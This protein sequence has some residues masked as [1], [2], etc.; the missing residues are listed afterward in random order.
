MANAAREPAASHGGGPGRV[1]RADDCSRKRC[2]GGKPRHCGRYGRVQSRGDGSGPNGGTSGASE[3]EPV[4]PVRPF[5]GWVALAGHCKRSTPC[6]SFVRTR[7]VRFSADPG[8]SYR[9]RDGAVERCCG[10]WD[11]KGRGLRWCNDRSAL[12]ALAG[13]S[14]DVDARDAEHSCVLLRGGRRVAAPEPH[15]IRFDV[16]ARRSQRSC[17]AGAAPVARRP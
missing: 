10:A 9:T 16:Q 8:H 6:A 7:A 15:L 14:R 13:R 12:G 17:R 1:P 5:P 11:G 4:R 2:A 3:S